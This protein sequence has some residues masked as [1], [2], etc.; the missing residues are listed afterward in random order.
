MSTKCLYLKHLQYGGTPYE[1]LLKYFPQAP[2]SL[3][4][5]PPIILDDTITLYG[6][7]EVYGQYNIR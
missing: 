6:G 2:K 4:A 7:R 3:L 5:L 1:E